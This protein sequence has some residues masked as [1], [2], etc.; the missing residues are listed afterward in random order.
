MAAL[1]LRRQQES[2][3][4]AV[5]AAHEAD[6]RAAD[7]LLAAAVADRQTAEADAIVAERAGGDIGTVEWHRNWI[8]RLSRGVDRAQS[9]RDERAGRVRD[10]AAVWRE[11]RR[12]RLGL[13][14]MRDRALR[15]FQDA[16]RRIEQAE[17]DELARLRYVMPEG[18]GSEL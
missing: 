15:R 13:E 8:V 18:K 9:E 10:A 6:L 11:A 3:A 14:R 12:K 1:D 17:F 2:A 5:L 4:S 7:A 16:E